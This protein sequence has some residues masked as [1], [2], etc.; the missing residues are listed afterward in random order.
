AAV[1]DLAVALL[2][3][4]ERH[5]DDL[6]ADY[7]YLQPAQP[8]TLGHLVLAWA[9]PE[10]RDAERLRAAARRLDRSPAGAG[11]SA[12]SRWPLDRSR[13]ATLLGFAAVDRHV[14][15]AMWAADG[16]EEL[17]AAMAIQATHMAQLAQ[18]VE[19]RASQEFAQARL[20]DRHSRASALMPQKRNPYALALIRAHGGQAAGD[21]ATVLTTL[22]TGS[23]RTDHFHVLNG[24]VPR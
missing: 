7:T 16:Y 10:L 6:A 24:L 15:D 13:L 22:H 18:D 14:R 3:L 9:L 21:L 5:G 19:A 23:A 17:L 8:T 2:D 20:A 4:A 1:V 11:G 12:G